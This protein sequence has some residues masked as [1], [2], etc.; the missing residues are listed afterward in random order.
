MYATQGGVDVVAVFEYGPA[1]EPVGNTRG[2]DERVVRNCFNL[3]GRCA[4]TQRS[5]I[6]IEFEDLPVTDVHRI[7]TTHPIKLNA[8]I[9]R[10]PVGVG[11]PQPDFLP[12]DQRGPQRDSDDAAAA[13]EVH[14]GEHAGI[15]H[16]CDQDAPSC[17][18]VGKWHC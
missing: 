11:D 8:I 17:R 3:S 5:T 6:V 10:P 4:K 7:E 18:A 9:T 15:A 12:A 2:D 16:A 14:R 1:P 13:R